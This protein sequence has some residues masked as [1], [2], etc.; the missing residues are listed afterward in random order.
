VNGQ[1]RAARGFCFRVMVGDSTDMPAQAI[2]AITKKAMIMS[3]L[4]AIDPG[5]NKLG[6]AFFINNIL[7]ATKTLTTDKQTPLERRLDIADKLQVF[8][9][10]EADIAS[11]EPLLLGRNNNFMQ[12]LL[13]YIEFITGGAVKFVHPMTLK[14]YTGSGSNDKFEMALAIGEKLSD[15]EQEILAAAISREAFD[16][17]DA[18]AVGLWALSR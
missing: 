5:S 17:T 11:E 15:K 16:E 3:S 8:I 7:V 12:R 2:S 1:L 18:V 14:A 10:A 13:G 9:E 4:V 6:L